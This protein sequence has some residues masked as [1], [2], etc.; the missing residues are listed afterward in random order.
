MKQLN[1]NS[2]VTSP[3]TTYG[4]STD[5]I[6][7]D[8]LKEQ[9]IGPTT[10]KS[11]E[12]LKTLI[13]TTT[14]RI[15]KSSTVMTTPRITTARRP[16]LFD[17]PPRPG[18]FMEGL[19][20]F[21]NAIVPP[22][23]PARPRTTKKPEKRPFPSFEDEDIFDNLP[24][25]TTKRPDDDEILRRS[26]TYITPV[27][28][29]SFTVTPSNTLGGLSNTELQRLI[30]QLEGVQKD[31]KKLQDL[32]LTP[33]KNLQAKA[34]G[35]QVT[36]SGTSGTSSK[37]TKTDSRRGRTRTAKSTTASSVSAAN[38]IRNDE[39]ESSTKAPRRVTLPPVQLDPVPGVP[40]EGG[41][42]VRGNLLK[43]A[44]NVTKAISQFFGTAI[45]VRF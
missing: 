18:R 5:A 45:Q 16:S 44:V 37:N 32:D 7:A 27:V 31:P 17:D 36:N 25:K 38:S 35:V 20:W 28:D 21:L 40:D 19:N 13:E 23:P 6:L 29:T 30:N 3:A 11:V 26:P 34:T 42:Q 39:K 22:L 10:P 12:R 15:K 24:V 33:L 14:K 41:F 4:R 1:A 8:L 9:G 2:G 43:A